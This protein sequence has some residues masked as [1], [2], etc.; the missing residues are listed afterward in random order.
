LHARR[1][2]LAEHTLRILLAEDNVANQALAAGLLRRDRHAVTIVDNGVAA[3]AA[4]I[5]GDFDVVLMD[6]QM[7][8]MSGLDATMEI[9]R[10]EVS[11]GTHIR[12]IAMTAHVMQADRARCLA[13]G[14][15]DY[16]PKPIATDALRRAL[17]PIA[18]AAGGTPSASFT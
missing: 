1:S 4:A 2:S 11:T 8:V 15:D 17:S 16:L 3:V 13:A 5:T 9:R 7:P 18:P 6:I 10:H 12:I 14:V